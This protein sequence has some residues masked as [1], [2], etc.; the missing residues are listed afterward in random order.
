M[1]DRSRRLESRFS[2]QSEVL[3]HK[4]LSPVAGIS[5]PKITTSGNVG[6]TE[7]GVAE[8]LSLDVCFTFEMANLNGFDEGETENLARPNSAF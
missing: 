8:G 5:A 4:I 3:R 7:Q 2:V 1:T 6:E